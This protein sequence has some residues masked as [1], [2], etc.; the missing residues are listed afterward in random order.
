MA[1]T[2]L[3]NSREEKLPS[4]QAAVPV[5]IFLDEGAP[6]IPEAI[7]EWGKQ[8]TDYDL[9]VVPFPNLFKSLRIYDFQVVLYLHKMIFW[10]HF[11]IKRRL[12]CGEKPIFI[13]ITTDSNFLD[14]AK[15]GLNQHKKF[16]SKRCIRFTDRSVVFEESIPAEVFVLFV[17]GDGKKILTEKVLGKL[18]SFLR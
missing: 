6:A 15:E 1:Q 3:S 13:F 5:Y 2:G 16:R 18:Q 4:S 7:E 12:K 8:R 9:K 14:D 10:D 11:E 17:K